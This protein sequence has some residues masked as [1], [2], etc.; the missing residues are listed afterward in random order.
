MSVRT[1]HR[2]TAIALLVLVCW[3]SLLSWQLLRG[4]SPASSSTGI[5]GPPGPPGPAGPAGPPGLPTTPSSH[6]TAITVTLPLSSQVCVDHSHPIPA[7]T[8]VSLSSVDGGIVPGAGTT[9]YIG[10]QQHLYSNFEP[11]HLNVVALD[12]TTVLLGLGQY[13]VVGDADGG[14][15]VSGGSF[16]FNFSAGAAAPGGWGPAFAL[17]EFV[18]EIVLLECVDGVAVLVAVGGG[19][20]M[21]LRVDLSTKRVTA[22]P[23]TSFVKGASVDTDTAAIGPSIFAI[24][25]Y[26]GTRNPIE[27]TAIA[28]TVHPNLTVTFGPP[29]VY[30]PNHMFHQIL[31]LG[32]GLF[33]LGFPDDDL[34]S[35][36]QS[37]AS[38]MAVLVASVSADLTVTVWSADGHG[39]PWL[40]QYV[41][42]YYFFDMLLLHRVVQS[43]G[44]TATAAMA[45]V[46]RSAADAM[47]IVTFTVSASGD[48]TRGYRSVGCVFG[49]QLTATQP[50][51][52]IGYNYFATVPLFPLPAADPPASGPLLRSLKGSVSF[53]ASVAKN[54][55]AV[56]WQDTSKHGAVEA[57]LVSYTVQSGA[58]A[59]VMPSSQIAPP[60]PGS[61]VEHWWIAGGALPHGRMM[62]LTTLGSGGNL[63]VVEHLGEV[64]GVVASAVACGEDASRV[65]VT[66]SGKVWVED[67]GVREG[68]VPGVSVWATSRG[69]LVGGTSATVRTSRGTCDL[70]IGEDG[71]VGLTTSEGAVW[72]SPDV[73]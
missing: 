22:G 3:L 13:V 68:A 58:L 6:P 30:S 11:N 2:L 72:V 47:T 61:D 38:P 44:I 70:L 4:T 35:S 43:D 41:L 55:F 28:G 40:Q 1:W 37:V 19:G 24:S 9:V 65:N 12:D 56:V 60:I 29:V 63:T 14:D 5:T 71:C 31:A 62:L 46:D 25:Y 57:V 20:A 73:C 8:P 42:G 69:R 67:G 34:A 7:N 54:D 18:D 50:G 51:A 10:A 64:V 26:A 53:K 66:V 49:S 32:P 59:L 27:L 39:A 15:W 45:V 33:V 52:T 21:G 36:A 48:G 16:P 23:S 17:P